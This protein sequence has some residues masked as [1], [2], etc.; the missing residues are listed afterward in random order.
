MMGNESMVEYKHRKYKEA[1]KLV[2]HTQTEP[3]VLIPDT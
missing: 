2:K 3:E 1:I